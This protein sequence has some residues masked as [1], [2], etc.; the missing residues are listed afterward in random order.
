MVNHAPVIYSY[1]LACCSGGG[2]QKSVD[3][4][5]DSA[6][7]EIKSLSVTTN[8]N[9]LVIETFC[10]SVHSLPWFSQS[11]YIILKLWCP[12]SIYTC[13]SLFACSDPTTFSTPTVLP[14]APPQISHPT[15]LPFC[16]NPFCIIKFVLISPSLNVHSICSMDLSPKSN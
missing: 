16:T 10:S 9:F 12:L 14:S 8:M 7:K 11:F 6:W 5:I 1:S 4:C 3:N 15:S 13:P 2:E